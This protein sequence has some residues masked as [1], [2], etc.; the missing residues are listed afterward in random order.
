METLIRGIDSAVPRLMDL[1]SDCGF[2]S[3]YLSTIHA[4]QA[5]LESER[6]DR[7]ATF[8]TIHLNPQPTVQ[9][10]SL[11]DTSHTNNFTG[12]SP[13]ESEKEADMAA[14]VSPDNTW[15]KAVALTCRTPTRPK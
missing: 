3:L 7:E 14:G 10:T 2:P 6:A 9:S 8:G 1:V 11:F 5:Y 12:R 13:L 4:L 15:L